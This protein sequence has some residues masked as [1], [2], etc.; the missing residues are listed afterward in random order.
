MTL[1]AHAKSEDPS[2]DIPRGWKV[3]RLKTLL[4]EPLTYGAN[5]AADS[6]DPDNPRFVRI[7]DIT[8]DGRL[9]PDTFRS[10]PMEKAQPYLL[11]EGDL[12]FARS[13]A[14]VG[15]SVMYSQSWGICCF[16]GYLIRAR[17]DPKTVLPR[18]L[19]YFSESSTYWQHIASEQI[20]ATIQNVSAERYG[21][22]P[23][24]MP[25]LAGQLAIVNFLDGETTNIDAVI[26][27]QEQLVATL[28]EE[29]TAT[30]THTVTKGLDPGVAVQDSGVEWIGSLPVDWTTSRIRYACTI[31]TGFPF[32]S[33]GFTQDATD[34]PLLRGTNVGVDCVDWTDIVY[35]PQSEAAALSEYDLRPGDIVMGLD[36]PFI[37]AGIRVARIGSGDVPSLL[38]QRVA[39]IRAVPPF[40]QDFLFYLLTGPGIVHHLTPMFTGVSVPHVSPDQVASFPVPQP[41]HQEQLQIVAHLKARCAQVDALIVKAKRVID[42]LREYRSALITDAVTSKIDVRG[43]A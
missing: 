31:L 32:K 16:A 11:H 1:P 4:K 18:Y 17:P 8:D 22:L 20:Q 36:R 15:K 27:K 33:E 24:P 43:A 19:R 38:L 28:R 37:G 39:R 21:N 23:V 30:I 9:K 3:R 40:D 6:D 14:T 2:L 26:A 35:W 12:L 41:S 25:D 29:R 10:L 5:E 7:T 42:T 34:I 13:G